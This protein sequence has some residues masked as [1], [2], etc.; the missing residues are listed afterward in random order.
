MAPFNFNFTLTFALYKFIL[1]I[2]LI[3]IMPKYFEINFKS[4]EHYAK[5]V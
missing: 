5:A 4:N 2:K 3:K 1:K